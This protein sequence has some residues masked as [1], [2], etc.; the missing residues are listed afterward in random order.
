MN[1]DIS[2]DEMRAIRSLD[3]FNLQ[4]LISEIHDHGWISKHPNVGGKSLLPMILAAIA[5]QGRG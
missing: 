3:D 2:A 5:K 4:M 1:Q